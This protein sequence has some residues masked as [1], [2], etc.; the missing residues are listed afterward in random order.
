MAF[1]RRKLVLWLEKRVMEAV[2]APLKFVRAGLIVL[3][4]AIAALI[5][6]E[7]TVRYFLEL[8]LL[9]F[10]ELTLYIIFWFYMLGAAHATHERSHI[11]GGIV[12]QVFKNKPKVS[13]SF[14]VWAAF[15]SFGLSCLVTVWAYDLFIWNI[16]RKPLARTI[17]L[18]LP[19]V[20][21]QL[22]LLV[23]FVLISLYFLVELIGS[24][25][26]VLSIRQGGAGN[27]C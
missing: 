10:E 21:D 14:H 15:I 17:H 27:K 25:R 26:D 18:Y 4:F 11:V 22:S 12:H 6:G 9:W 1:T 7:V 16:G 13:G 20:Y 19:L 5:F 3:N 23:G 8:P 2:S 24:V